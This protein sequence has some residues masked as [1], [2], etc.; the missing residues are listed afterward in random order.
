MPGRAASRCQA[1]F[2][3]FRSRVRRLREEVGVRLSFRGKKSVSGRSRCQI[4]IWKKS[5]SDHHLEEVGV[6]SSFGGK[7]SMSDHHL[8][9][10]SRCHRSP[11]SKKAGKFRRFHTRFANFAI[12]DP[13]GTAAP[14]HGSSGQPCSLVARLSLALFACLRV[15][16]F[17]TDRVCAW[18]YLVISAR[19][20]LNLRRSHRAQANVPS[21]PSMESHDEYRTG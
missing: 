14:I 17:S 4:I 20:E 7:K 19:I 6:R 15:L 2:L 3:V 1:W 10:R 18:G 21:E 5:V 9:A 8:A 13:N 16:P 11:S 12:S